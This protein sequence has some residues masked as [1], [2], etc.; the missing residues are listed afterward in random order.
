MKR[1]SSCGLEKELDYF[2][3]H[4]GNYDG[5]S[6]ACKKCSLGKAKEYQKTKEGLVSGIYNHQKQYSKTKPY[7]TPSYNNK[8]LREWLF[9]QKKFHEMYDLWVYNDYDE[10][11]TPSCDR[12]ENHIGYMLCNIQL[13]TWGE[14][15]I[16]SGEDVRNGIDNKRSRAVISIDMYSGE[17]VE[18]YSMS[19]ASR[20]TGTFVSNIFKA[21]NGQYIHTGNYYWKYK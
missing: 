21:C 19:Q 6:Y 9:S 12:I 15:L 5:H 7:K 14:H 20:E 10:T 4:K 8:E 1:C 13:T 18:Y 16:K 3:K 17:E 11:L 2:Y